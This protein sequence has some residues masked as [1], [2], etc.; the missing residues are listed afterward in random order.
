MTRA[1]ARTWR[2]PAPSC[3]QAAEPYDVIAVEPPPPHAA[4]GAGHL[5]A[6]VLPPDAQPAGCRVVSRRT[7]CR[8]NQLPLAGAQ[9]VVRA[10]CLAFED[11]SLWSGA[12]YEWLLVGTQRRRGA[13]RRRR[14]PGRGPRPVRAP[15][16]ARSESSVPSSSG[17]CSSPTPPSSRSGRLAPPRSSTIG[18]AASA[19]GRRPARTSRCIGRCRSP[20][21]VA[22]GGGRAPWRWAVAQG[23]ARAEPRL[24]RV[25]RCLQPRLRGRG[26]PAGAGRAVGGAGRDDAHDLAAASAR[27]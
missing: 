1:C 5:L 2:M 10:F 15:T 21:P 22:R 7:G 23:V 14:S 25:A 8:V 9:A 20:R 18:R 6:R 24:V 17:R 26:A 19:A 27:Q 16:C 11:C 12:G 13:V 3:A 4:G